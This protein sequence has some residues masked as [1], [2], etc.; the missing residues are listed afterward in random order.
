MQKM[1]ELKID[2]QNLEPFKQAVALL[3]DIYNTTTDVVRAKI[4]AYVGLE[5]PSDEFQV[6]H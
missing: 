3:W 1:A 5:D 4:A 2:V 6:M